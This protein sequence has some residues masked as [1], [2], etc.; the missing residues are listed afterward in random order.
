MGLVGDFRLLICGCCSSL[1][2]LFHP[3]IQQCPWD[4][5]SPQC[6][7]NMT[8]TFPTDTKTGKWG[9]RHSFA[10]VKESSY[11]TCL[12]R[13]PIND[14]LA[15]PKAGI[16][17]SC[18]TC[19]WLCCSLQKVCPSETKS[20]NFCSNFLEISQLNAYIQIADNENLPAGLAPSTTSKTVSNVIPVNRD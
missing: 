14:C 6:K 17:A 4:I 15:G 5:W 3:W 8:P 18:S 1:N 13:V 12:C 10:F 7:Q 11:F 2:Q 16:I 20:Q 9:T 19:P